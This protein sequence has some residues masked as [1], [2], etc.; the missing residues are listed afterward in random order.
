MAGRP[1]AA[2]RDFDARWD[3]LYAESVAVG[4]PR[5]WPYSRSPEFNPRAAYAQHHATRGCDAGAH[6]YTDG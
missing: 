3:R 5:R 6:T 2:D 4:F 1:T